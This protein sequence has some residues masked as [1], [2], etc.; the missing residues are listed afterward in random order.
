MINV[1]LSML[2]TVRTR[3]MPVKFT[4]ET[5]EGRKD[6][7]PVLF[8]LVDAIQRSAFV[9]CYERNEEQESRYVRAYTVRN[10]FSDESSAQRVG[11][12]SRSGY[13]QG[14]AGTAALSGR[15]WRNE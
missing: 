6:M 11:S 15:D 4:A 14:G 13:P 2:S 1:L 3:N 5:D 8:N 9:T 10:D 7:R 12:L